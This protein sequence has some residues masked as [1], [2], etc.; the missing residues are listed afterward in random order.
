MV[1]WVGFDMDECVGSLMPLFA[2]V[3]T[4]PEKKYLNILANILI[5]S[6]NTKRTWLVRP[7]MYD[8][9]ELLYKAYKSGNIYG[10]FI[11]SNNGSQELVDFIAIY[12]NTWMASKHIESRVVN[13]FKMAICRSSP[14]RTPGSLEKSF[15][16][17]QRTL[18]G[19]KLPTLSGP[20]DLLFFDDMAHVLTNEISNYVKVR[21]YYNRCPI[22][23]VIDGLSDFRYYVS[24]K[25]WADICFKARHFAAADDGRV[26]VRTPP[27]VSEYLIDRS[28]F[29]KAFRRFLVQGSRSRTVRKKDH[30]ENRRCPVFP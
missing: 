9:M 17:V 14:I 12:L 30:M 7:A 16:E 19:Y 21:P 10:A 23:K 13:I 8:C 1:K 5:K 4:L 6:E 15:S 3:T 28:M 29:Q 22:E 11:F 18:I 27:V 20:R 26:Y 25:A 2:F 24:D